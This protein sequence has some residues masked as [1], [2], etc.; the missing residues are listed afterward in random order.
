MLFEGNN[1]LGSPQL[2]STVL[3][4]DKPGE[5]NDEKTP[6]DEEVPSTSSPQITLEYNTLTPSNSDTNS[7]VNSQDPTQTEIPNKQIEDSVG[8][9]GE[10]NIPVTTIINETVENEN[11]RPIESDKS[12]ENEK[13]DGTSEKPIENELSENEKPIEN[14]KLEENDKPVENHSAEPEKPINSSEA[15]FTTISYEDNLPIVTNKPDT[16][17]NIEGQNTLSNSDNESQDYPVPSTE[18][19]SYESTITNVLP[20]NDQNQPESNLG[21]ENSI[22]ATTFEPNDSVVEQQVDN[23]KSGANE[24]TVNEQ[25]NASPV[26]YVTDLPESN[27]NPL[28]I[29]HTPVNT[30]DTKPMLV[31]NNADGLRPS[32]IDD[33]IS[34]VNMVKDA[35]KNSLETL[36]KP[37]ENNYQ[38]TEVIENHQPT[39]VPEYSASPPS[40]NTLPDKYNEPQTAVNGTSIAPELQTDVVDEKSTENPTAV[41]PSDEVGATQVP[42]SSPSASTDQG[43]S[44]DLP[45]YVPTKQEIPASTSNGDVNQAGEIADDKTPEITT[46]KYSPDSPEQVSTSNG[47]ETSGDS[48]A[49]QANVESNANP[50]ETVVVDDK[51][52]EI[53]STQALPSAAQHEGTLVDD[54]K[55]AAE[56]KP[57]TESPVLPDSE[58]NNDNAATGA[59]PAQAAVGHPTTAPDDDT[60]KRFGGEPSSSPAPS[61]AQDDKRPQEDNKRPQESGET[62]NA[63]PQSD[64][65]KPPSKPSASTPS[66]PP[67]RPS[68]TPIPQSTWTQKPFHHDS[69]SEA[70]QQPDQSFPDDYDDENEAVYGPGT[71]R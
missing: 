1:Q 34:S 69:T 51:S 71:C 14:D 52:P 11:D 3:L 33:I 18:I 17:N 6:I 26:D 39:T 22:T 12:S 28:E 13:L 8:T 66:A 48:I 50:T 38:T 37:V 68:Y 47:P 5:E 20:T 64:T 67:H 31:E 2:I 58:V 65:E 43:V 61:V 41:Q 45:L 23:N 63:P 15:D 55:P 4:E 27:V 60:D 19:P 44:T 21:L 40:E 7:D 30:D 29:T 49:P 70:P 56:E 46:T 24:P 62:V 53:S 32:S 57:N 25:S 36:S 59:V 10:N 54:Q 9:N 35:V 42:T 16:S